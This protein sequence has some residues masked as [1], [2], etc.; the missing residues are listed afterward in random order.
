MGTHGAS[1][2][3]TNLMDRSGH[4]SSSGSR[5]HSHKTKKNSLSTAKMTNLIEALTAQKRK[6]S[7]NPRILNEEEEETIDDE[8]HFET[9]R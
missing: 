5:I 3:H 7:S 4:K 9:E 6:P 1:K 2:S 8:H